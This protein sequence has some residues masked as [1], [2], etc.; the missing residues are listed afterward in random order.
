ML[1][2][3][4]LFALAGCAPA[5]VSLDASE[6][7]PDG[8]STG[9][10]ASPYEDPPGAGTEPEETHLFDGAS[11]RIVAPASGAFLP[12]EEPALF[13]AEL[14]AADGV[15]LDGSE[16]TWTSS[17]DPAWSGLGESFEDSTLDVGLHDLTAEVALPNGDRLVY[18]VGGILR[19][20]TFAGTYS[21]LFSVDGSYNGLVF[22]CSGTGLTVCE[23]YGTDITGDA[24]CL[25]SILGFDLPLS[26]VF[27]LENAA[28]VVTGT[29]G[30]DIFGLFAFDFPA[31][32]TLFPAAEGLAIDFA[33]E[34]PLTGIT[35][36][37]VYDA[38]RVSLDAGL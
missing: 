20:S 15:P 23:P 25:V 1:R 22:T 2:A 32:G 21:G 33:G 37:G 35:I 14:L 34:V 5:S 17:L 9:W 12:I 27:E 24:A 18:A 4:G 26:F 7:A 28:G 29:A 36:T 30:A 38:E 8:A 16:I 6:A 10:T 31:E 3:V 19:Q 11:M 13:E